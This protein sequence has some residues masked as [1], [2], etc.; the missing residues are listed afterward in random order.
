MVR[1]PNHAMIQGIHSGSES[2]QARALI[3][4]WDRLETCT[5]TVIIPRS[6]RKPQKKES[7]ILQNEAT[8]NNGINK[9]TLKMGQNEAKRSE[10]S[11]ST[12]RDKSFGISQAVLAV[13]LFSG[14]RAKLVL[15]LSE[16]R[17][18][19]QSATPSPCAS[20]AGAMLFRNARFAPLVPRSTG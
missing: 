20:T 12:H 11:R 4:A 9:S 1:S 8:K 14:F 15:A 18:A 7:K 3:V 10:K 16:G 2:R 13:A 17:H 19:Q 5:A 6:L